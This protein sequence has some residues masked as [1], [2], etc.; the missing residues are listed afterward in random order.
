MDSHNGAFA[1]LG[2]GNGLCGAVLERE[3]KLITSRQVLWLK[4]WAN[5]TGS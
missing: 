1:G 3:G 4:P 5:R 2:N